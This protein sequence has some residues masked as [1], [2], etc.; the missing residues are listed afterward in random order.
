M[1]LSRTVRHVLVGLIIAAAAL[2]L[3]YRKMDTSELAEA[4]SGISLPLLMLVPVPLALSYVMRIIRWRVLLSPMGSVSFGQASGPLLAGF[5]INSLLP[6]RAGEF[7]RAL[8]LARKTRISRS[9]SLATVFLARLF[10]GLTLTGM[11]L[12]VLILLWA[13]IEPKVRLGLIG[14]GLLYLVVLAAFVLLRV[15]RVP[16]IRVLLVPFG[17][18]GESMKERIGRA[19]DSFADG[20][21][22]LQ[23]GR[24]V[25]MA[26]LASMGVWFFIVVSVVPVFFALELPLLWYYPV[27]VIIL[28]ALGML[29]PTPAGTGT[30]HAALA[31]ALPVLTV[32]SRGDAAVLALIF[33]LTQFLPVIVAGVIAAVAEGVSGSDIE[34]AEESAEHSSIGPG[35]G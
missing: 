11:A 26:S 16:T 29:I 2:V 32:L 28:A 20:L 17:L 10:D 35:P 6:A 12:L 5:M 18:L 1:R 15:G 7:I 14:A 34:H 8:L 3:T 33:H 13:R 31:F 25:L 24:E 30:I 22:A 21:G 27:L 19:L 23:S 4:L 9:A